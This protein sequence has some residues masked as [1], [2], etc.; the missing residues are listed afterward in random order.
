M[1]LS[2]T[3]IKRLLLTSGMSLFPD[4]SGRTLKMTSFDPD[5]PFDENE[6]LSEY[7]PAS[8]GIPEITP[9]CEVLNVDGSPLKLNLG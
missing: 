7:D 3:E 9:S 4:G 8:V 1:N 5:C 6:M 2:G